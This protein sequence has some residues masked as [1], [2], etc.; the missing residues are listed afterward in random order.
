MTPNDPPLP[1][2]LLV[3]G[4]GDGPSMFEPL[5]KTDLAEQY[6]LIPVALPGFHGAPAFEETHLGSMAD[7]VAKTAIREGAQIALGHSIASIIVSLA[8]L[9]HPWPIDTVLSLEGNLTEKDGYFSATAADYASPEAFVDAFSK[10]LAAMATDNPTL[11]RYRQ[12]VA[13]ADPR[14]LWQ[15]GRDSAAFSQQR[16][17]G[18]LLVAVPK[19]WY[20][21]NPDNCDPG[22]V[23]WLKHRALPNTVLP[24][25]SHWAS[26][27]QPDHLAAAMLQALSRLDQAEKSRNSASR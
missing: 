20:F 26:L 3:A 25:A 10:Q 21:Y 1:G 23:R 11:A 19:V 4:F 15:L 6:R 7:F 16:V 18:N 8:A 2:I 13:L 14:A 5:F 12:K 22:S 27:D 24:G 17:P 9:Q